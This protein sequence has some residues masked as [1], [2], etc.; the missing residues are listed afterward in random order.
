MKD[1]L[2]QEA[3]EELDLIMPTNASE[4]KDF[5]DSLIDKVSKA[6]DEERWCGT[7]K[8]CSNGHPSFWKTIVQSKEWGKWYKHAS[9]N[10]LF[11]VDESQECGWMSLNHWNSFLEF[12]KTL[13]LKP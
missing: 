12:I 2:K 13:Q 10:H 4:I 11:D 8:G 6:K 5:I 9:K 3:R 1:K 7:C